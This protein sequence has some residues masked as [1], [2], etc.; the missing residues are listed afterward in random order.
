[1]KKVAFIGLGA[2]GL[3]MANNIIKSGYDVVGYDCDASRLELHIANGG[4]A[5]DSPA[6]AARGAE[7]V[8]TMLPVG[9][10]VSSALFDD[11]GIIE[12]ISEGALFIDMSTIHPMESDALREKLNQR[13]ITMIDAP[14]GRTAA[15]A[16]TGTLLILAG[17]DEASIR[18]AQPIFNC[19]GN[20]VIDCGG[21]GK[22]TRIKIV[23]NFMS[24]TLNA[25]TAECLALS[26]KIG[27]DR[28]LAIEVMSGTPAIKSHMLTTYPNKVFK[29]DLTPDFPIDLANKDLLISLA[30]AE[31]LKINM[32]MG[33]AASVVYKDA[34]EGG[35]GNQDWTAL[36]AMLS[37]EMQESYK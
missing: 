18:R 22:G 32:E 7:F 23:N 33:R 8:I 29:N 4:K 24:V 17:G 6:E 25:L 27:L 19:M 9:T 34:Q 3:S 11:G 28:N 14:V 16:A 30:L 20:A 2:M 1:M 35:R 10:I 21:A 13:G 15:H 36:Y 31:D 12:T 37:P 26:D 5:A